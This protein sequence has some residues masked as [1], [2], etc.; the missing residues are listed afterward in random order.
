MTSLAMSFYKT[1]RDL[2]EVQILIN[3]HAFEYHVNNGLLIL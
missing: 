2:E 1:M 3:Y